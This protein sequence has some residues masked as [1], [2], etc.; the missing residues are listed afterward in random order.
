[1]TVSGFAR[2]KDALTC[3]VSAHGFQLMQLMQ[4]EEFTRLLTSNG[5]LDFTQWSQFYWFPGRSSLSKPMGDRTQ[6][7]AMARNMKKAGIVDTKVVHLL[8]V[9]G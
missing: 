1:M 3:A 6:R 2:H 7:T 8:K 4:R 5:F 9:M